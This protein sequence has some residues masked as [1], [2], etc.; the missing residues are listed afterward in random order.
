MKCRILLA[1]FLLFPSLSWADDIGP[2]WV[3]SN[4]SGGVTVYVPSGDNPTGAM[5]SA[6][7]MTKN[8][9]EYYSAGTTSDKVSVDSSG[10]IARTMIEVIRVNRI[11]GS[12]AIYS[13]PVTMYTESSTTSTALWNAVA[14]DPA[15]FPTLSS[16]FTSTS[17]QPTPSVGVVA[18]VGGVNYKITSYYGSNHGSSPSP[19]QYTYSSYGYLFYGTGHNSDW[20]DNNYT[21]WRA[22]PTSDAATRLTPNYPALNTALGS[23]GSPA[24]ADIDKLI[25]TTPDSF[26]PSYTP[27]ASD[28]LTQPPQGSP[29]T[30][31]L[32]NKLYMP[33]ALP[34]QA[35]TSSNPSAG[36]GFTPSAG[37]AGSSDS[38]SLANIA[39]NTAAIN[40]N[41]V[42]SADYLANIYNSLNQ[43]KD[44]LTT[45]AGSSASSQSVSDGLATY[46]A[47]LNDELGNAKSNINGTP[48]TFNSDLDSI[49][50]DSERSSFESLFNNAKSS[51]AL[52]SVKNSVGISASGGTS[53]LTGM[54][55]NHSLTFD[56]SKFEWFF[57]LF[58]QM[59]LGLC[60][61]YAF[62]L[63]MKA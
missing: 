40:N 12:Q 5:S 52:A 17:T 6:P 53:Q 25:A 7:I 43:L 36:S 50:N 29:L 13:T 46:D 1:I 27:T 42:R 32:F 57:V 24:V 35:P 49:N 21:S 31:D 44:H 38:Q 16:S 34:S 62:F 54:V 33:A 30:S 56:F 55:F 59:F 10:R 45:G 9:K 61:L 37:G 58:G 26:S 51:G 4:S 28:A 41:L 23:A 18:T 11:D 14:S 20:N 3:Q 2:G 22:G 19:G 60:Y 48:T 8:G 63:T 39:G 47:S 15:N